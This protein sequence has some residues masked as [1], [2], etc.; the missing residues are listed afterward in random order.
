MAP[1]DS[2]HGLSERLL[3]IGTSGGARSLGLHSG[4]SAGSP[5]DL[6]LVALEGPDTLGVPP[7]EAVVFG[8]GP[9]HVRQVWVGGDPLLEEGRHRYRDAFMCDVRPHL[10][11]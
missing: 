8:A 9:A 11:P 7:L 5:A 1:E 3:G 6:C 10:L 2:R 4:L